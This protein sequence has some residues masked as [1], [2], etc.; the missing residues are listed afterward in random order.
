MKN[1]LLL[2]SNGFEALE[3]SAFTDVFGWNEIVG[4]KKI[5]LTTSSISSP[6]MATWNFKVETELPLKD[7]DVNDF[8]AL[9]VPGGFGRAGFFTDIKNTFFLEKIT[10]FYLQNKTIAGVCTGVIPL[11]ESGILKEKKATTYLL[12]NERYFKQ[13][14]NWSQK[15]KSMTDIKPRSYFGSAWKCRNEILRF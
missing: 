4:N 11:A 9:V 8:D 2:L 12:D 1:V 13:L 6:I 3:A 7:I 15:A 14:K 10:E 5:K